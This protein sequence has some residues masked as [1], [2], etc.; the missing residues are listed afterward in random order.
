MMCSVLFLFLIFVFYFI[1]FIISFSV[2]E[3]L[4]YVRPFEFTNVSCHPVMAAHERRSKH[5]WG[6]RCGVRV[7][8][9]CSSYCNTPHWRGGGSGGGCESLE[10]ISV[11]IWAYAHRIGRM[12]S[13]VLCILFCVCV[14]VC[15]CM[16]VCVFFS[17]V[18]GELSLF[19]N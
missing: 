11:M 12:S 7:G 4:V 14:C 16:Y 3:Q 18:A 19:L 13:G 17:I 6:G 2:L 9:T 10:I 8:G 5:P 1:F 15:V